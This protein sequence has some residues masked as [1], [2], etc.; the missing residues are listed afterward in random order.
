MAKTHQNGCFLGCF[1]FSGNKKKPPKAFHAGSQK[2]NSSNNFL[3]WPTFRLSSRKS[4][5]KTVPVDNNSDKADQP[6]PPRPPADGKTK[7]SKLIKNKKKSDPKLISSKPQ[8]QNPVSNHKR[9]SRQNSKAD[10]KQVPPS[11]QAAARDKPK[12]TTRLQQGPDHHEQR[13]IIL[14]NRKLLDPLRSTG[15]SLPGS[16]KPKP[17][18]TKLSHTVSLPALEGSKRVVNPRVHARFNLKELQRKQNNEVVQKFDPLIGMSIIMVTLIIMLV[19]GRFCAIL[20]TSAWFYFCPRF[21]TAISDNDND[22]V[23]VKSTTNSNELDLNS[24]E[25]KKKVVLEGLLE[26]NVHRVTI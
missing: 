14:G 22:N 25:Y 21:R 4:R 19:W 6:P 23:T 18:P 26:R 5:T 24:E 13:K 16:P 15:S 10:I 1:G 11:N 7:T 2:K 17:K 12:E 20:C 9:P 3:S 8:A